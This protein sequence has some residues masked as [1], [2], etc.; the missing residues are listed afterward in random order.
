MTRPFLV[1]DRI[2]LVPMTS[3][4]LPLLHRLDSD[5]EV[6]RHLLGR[7]RTPAEID[8]FWAPRCSDTAF[9]AVGL[10]W[11]D[12]T[13]GTLARCG[14]RRGRSTPLPAASSASWA[15]T[16]PAPRS[17]SGG[18]RSRAEQGELVDEVSADDWR[19]E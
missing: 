19:H 3:D 13:P 8:E 11:W 2:E 5:P 18:T 10:G 16:T 17:V 14:P 6:M 15:C 4:H 1:P 12:L 9:D 7:A